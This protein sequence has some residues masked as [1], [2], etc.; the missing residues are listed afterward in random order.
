MSKPLAK[1]KKTGYLGKNTLE[2]T[3][4][5]AVFAESQKGLCWKGPPKVI[6]LFFEYSFIEYQTILNMLFFVPI[7]F[8]SDH[9]VTEGNSAV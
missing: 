1:G 3:S 4:L 5:T 9:L 7:L 8:L 2:V 6:C